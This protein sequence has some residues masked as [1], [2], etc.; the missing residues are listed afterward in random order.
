MRELDFNKNINIAELAPIKKGRVLGGGQKK[1]NASNSVAPRVIRANFSI[2][3]SEILYSLKIYTTFLGETALTLLN[4]L[5]RQKPEAPNR[6]SAVVP[7]KYDALVRLL[8]KLKI[9]QQLI[10]NFFIIFFLL[11]LI[12][13]VIFVFKIPKQRTRVATRLISALFSGNFRLAF[14]M[15][16]SIITLAFLSVTFNQ[17]TGR[18]LIGSLILLYLFVIMKLSPLSDYVAYLPI[19]REVLG[20]SIT[21]NMLP[22]QV[23]EL[24][25]LASA[26]LGQYIDLIKALNIKDLRKKKKLFSK[27]DLRLI[28]KIKKLLDKDQFWKAAKMMQEKHFLENIRLIDSLFSFQKFEKKN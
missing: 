6:A 3:A 4:F 8:K 18:P 24:S 14:R 17:I 1:I 12:D 7:K 20:I 22:A 16:F 5:E 27:E 9:N 13:G 11:A 2:S 28:L 25:P 23:Q 10:F 21:K 15:L 19:F 26:L